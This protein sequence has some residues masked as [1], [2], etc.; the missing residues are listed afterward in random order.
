MRKLAT[1]NF[2]HSAR[3]QS[4]ELPYPSPRLRSHASVELIS[5]APRFDDRHIQLSKAD[6]SIWQRAALAQLIANVAPRSATAISVALINEFGS[7]GRIFSESPDA[8]RRV[9]GDNDKIIQL[10]GSAHAAHCASLRS[11]IHLK[12]IDVI[13]QHLIDYLAAS[14]G[15]LSV[16]KLRVLFLDRSNRL[17]GDEIMAIGSLTSLTAYPRQI[18]RRALELSACGLVLVHNHPGGSIEPSESD[19]RFTNVL[20][21]V[22][23]QMEISVKD[24]IIIAANRW[25]SFSK[26]GLI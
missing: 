12:T 5:A 11:E 19:I 21:T 24:H 3:N 16:E 1:N 9:I 7:L 13:D 20:A 10:L 2:G 4:A 25:L 6:P 23:Q 18:F 22:G 8:L 14:M 15:G 26:R 17:A